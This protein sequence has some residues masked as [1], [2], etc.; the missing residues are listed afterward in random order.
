MFFFTLGVSRLRNRSAPWPDKTTCR[1]LAGCTKYSRQHHLFYWKKGNHHPCSKDALSRVKDTYMCAYI[2]VVHWADNFFL[3]MCRPDAIQFKQ[4]RGLMKRKS[5]PALQGQ[6]CSEV[7]VQCC[8]LSIP[9]SD[10][11]YKQV[12]VRTEE[13]VAAAEHAFIMADLKVSVYK[14]LSTLLNWKAD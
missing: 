11:S 3:C 9:Q 5:L 4:L 8:F 13:E 1:Y 7:G 12:A 6:L 10:W 14:H 2:H